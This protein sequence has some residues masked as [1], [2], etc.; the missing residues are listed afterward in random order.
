M[1]VCL[2]P[3][4]CLSTIL[5]NIL[6]VHPSI[7]P[8]FILSYLSVICRS[9]YHCCPPSFCQSICHSIDLSF[10]CSIYP[11]ICL[12]IILS[13]CLPFCSS[14]CLPVCR[15]IYPSL[16]NSSCNTTFCLLP[17]LEIQGLN[18]DLNHI[19]NSLL[20]GAQPWHTHKQKFSSGMSGSHSIQCLVILTAHNF[21]LFC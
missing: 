2:S 20:N 8:S 5:I 10:C 19:L 21:N 11:S 3:S 17:Q 13:F 6:S 16:S 7:H 9:I 15:Y 1:S 14:V 18:C 12:S 4:I